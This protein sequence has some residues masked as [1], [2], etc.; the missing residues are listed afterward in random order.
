MIQFPSAEFFDALR[1]RM[2]SDPER[3]RRLGTVD[4]TLV[5]KIDHPDRSEFFEI[6]FAGYRC[7]GTRRIASAAEAPGDA[8]VVEGSHAAW[9]E[10]IYNIIANGHA[11][12]EHTL[13]TLTLMDTPL[14]AYA[15]NQLDTDLFYR[16]AE[17]LQ[18]FFDGA[19]AIGA[20][21]PAAAVS[22]HLH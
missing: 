20:R 5:V 8:I 19:A 18:E 17:N 4:M 13:N 2:N 7:V 9:R 1:E 10:M 3:F 12:L 6:V 15:D 14:R 22:A 21:A 11:D 16:Y